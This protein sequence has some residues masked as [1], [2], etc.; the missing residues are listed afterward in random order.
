M[1]TILKTSVILIYVVK[2]QRIDM[3]EWRNRQTRTFKVRVGDHSG[4]SPVSRTIKN[5]GIN[6]SWY[7]YFLSLKKTDGT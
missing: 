2:R 7:L 6:A 4:S 3:R 1:L 5:K